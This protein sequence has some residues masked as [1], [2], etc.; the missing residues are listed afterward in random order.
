VK[1][2]SKKPLRL[3]CHAIAVG[4][5]VTAISPSSLIAS[6]APSSTFVGNGGDVQDLDLSVTLAV[7]NSV[8][9]KLAVKKDENICSCSDNWQE[10]GICKILRQMSQEEIS[11]CGRIMTKYGS[12]LAELASRQ[13]SVKFSWSED[14]MMVQS[15]SQKARP[16]DAVTQR[17]GK[18][19]IINRSRF[20][21]MPSSYRVALITHELF[22]LI[23]VDDGYI[24]DEQSAYPFASGRAMLNILGAA[25]AMEANEQNIFH[26][27]RSLQDVSKS[28]KKH[29]LTLSGGGVMHP[30]QTAK[31]LLKKD[32]TSESV[33]FGYAYRQGD[34]GLNLGLE[35]ISYTGAV[36]NITIEER[37]SIF[38]VGP[39]YRI[40]PINKYLS[41][42]NEL[43]VTFGLDA[44]YGSA[45]YS[46]KSLKVAKKDAAQVLTFGGSVR[47][48]IPLSSELWVTSGLEIRQLR[49]EYKKLQTKTIE[50]QS[51]VTIGGAYGF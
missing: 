49:Y 39:H 33:T 12:Q 31:P 47:A 30:E 36:S 14:K 34:L 26:E 23:K 24:S 18:K 32:R 22:H 35:T 29:W 11:A 40:N 15:Q 17:E 2:A 50:N 16:V 7:I 10:N 6:N 27:F 38:R 44:G 20:Y 9:S 1:I 42:W 3:F 43:F 41:R 13:S 45:N 48:Y 25:V 19:I 28:Q 46:A 51:V 5:L 21:S 37:L 8:A 4:L